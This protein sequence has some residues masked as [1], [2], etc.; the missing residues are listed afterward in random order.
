MPQSDWIT[1]NDGSILVDFVGRFENFNEDFNTVCKQIG[2][3]NLSLPHV[4]SSKRENY[5]EYYDDLTMKI[6]EQWFSKD[7]DKFGY[8][9]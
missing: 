9:F 7:I 2:K 3:N 4:K 8:R 1:D 6:V 5:R